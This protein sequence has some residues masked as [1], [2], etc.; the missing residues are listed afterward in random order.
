M[1]H[2]SQ[3]LDAFKLSCPLHFAGKFHPRSSGNISTYKKIKFKAQTHFTS[4]NLVESFLDKCHES[5]KQSK[6]SWKINYKLPN[7]L[8]WCCT[9]NLTQVKSKE[10][11]IGKAIKPPKQK[12]LNFTHKME[13]NRK[14]KRKSLILQL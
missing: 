2:S 9:W 13:N 7:S 6:T 8:R 12:I 1:G 11:R 5:G 14:G 4:H 10:F 3:W